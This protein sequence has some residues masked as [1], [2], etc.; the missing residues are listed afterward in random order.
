MAAVFMQDNVDESERVLHEQ[1]ELL[2]ALGKR[3]FRNNSF[4]FP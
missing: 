2:E 1:S 3:L 4:K